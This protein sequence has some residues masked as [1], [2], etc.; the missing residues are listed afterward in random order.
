MVE[1]IRW[2]LEKVSPSAVI[3]VLGQFYVAFVARNSLG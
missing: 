1:V 3:C 2:D